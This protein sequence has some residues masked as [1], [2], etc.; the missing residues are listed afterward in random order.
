MAKTSTHST[1]T[2]KAKTLTAITVAAAGVAA[3]AVA[4]LSTTQPDLLT[5]GGSVREVCIQSCQAKSCNTADLA[6]Q[7]LCAQEVQACMNVCPAPAGTVGLRADLSLEPLPLATKGRAYYQRLAINGYTEEQGQWNVIEGALPPGMKLDQQGLVHGTPTESD[8]FRFT[9][10]FSIPEVKGVRAAMAAKANIELVVASQGETTNTG[11]NTQAQTA[12]STFKITTPI[13]GMTIQKGVRYELTLATEGVPAN[14]SVIWYVSY[15]KLPDGLTLNEKGTILGTPVYEG[16]FAFGVSASL[17]SNPNYPVF[18]DGSIEVVSGVAPVT[19]Q[20]G[21]TSSG[22]NTVASPAAFSPV[23]TKLPEGRVNTYASFPFSLTN[24]SADRVWMVDVLP[25]GMRF[26][27]STRVLEGKPLQHGPFT[28]KIT[29]TKGSDILTKIYTWNV[30]ADVAAIQIETDL[31]DGVAGVDYS[32]RLKASGGSGSYQ[33]QLQNPAAV[34]GWTLSA[35]GELKVKAPKAGVYTFMARAQ[36][37]TASTKAEA[38][39]TVN[40]K[41]AVVATTDKE[42]E[43]TGA[44][45]GTTGTGKEEEKEVVKDS[46]GTDTAKATDTGSTDK[47]VALAFNDVGSYPDGFASFYYNAHPFEVV[48]GKTPHVYKISAGSLPDGLSMNGTGYITGTPTKTGTF[49]FTMTVT[50]A[51]NTVI[52]ANRVIMV[53]SAEE[54]STVIVNKDIPTTIAGASALQTRIDAFTRIGVRIH[55]LV[56]LQDDGNASTQDDST[57]YYLGADGRRHAFPNSRVYFSWFSNFASVRMI[58][59]R[60][61][62]DIP[63]GANIVYRPGVRLVKF[64]SVPTVYVVDLNRRL[65]AIRTEADAQAI[66]GTNWSQ[67]VDDISDAFYMDYRIDGTIDNPSALRPSSLTSSVVWPSDVLPL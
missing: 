2:T 15:G 3:F 66:Y 4:S 27:P 34:T 35:L 50:D 30:T 47:V 18:K 17:R 59:S 23:E 31:P 63:L 62:A 36:D 46:S 54:R 60:D 52:R 44:D 7:Q 26:T 14:D 48:G 42:E 45:T 40:I 6:Q 39:M 65:R 24:D 5:S 29:A 58:G 25:P 49:S 1:S 64:L 8:R 67:N 28:L 33:W 61:L 11:T 56:K 55:D 38:Q 12:A 41:P 43:K 21:A 16:A 57:V 32:A 9:I 19:G 51:E 37:A 13:V 10:Q 53:R 22:T 20:T